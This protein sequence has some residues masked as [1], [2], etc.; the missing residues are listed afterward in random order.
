MNVEDVISEEYGLDLWIKDDLLEKESWEKYR[1]KAPGLI[2]ELE[3][4]E[5][6]ADEMNQKYGTN[7]KLWARQ[8]PFFETRFSVKGM[9]EDEK[10]REIEKHAKAM[11]ETWQLFREWTRNVGREIYTKTTNMRLGWNE[12]ISKVL[13]LLRDF[14]GAKFV[15]KKKAGVVLSAELDS[16]DV[17]NISANRGVGFFKETRDGIV[18]ISDNL[19]TNDARSI[20]EYRLLKSRSGKNK[21]RIAAQKVEDVKPFRGTI[22]TPELVEQVVRQVEVKFAIKITIRKDRP[23]LVTSFNTGDLRPYGKLYEIERHAKALAETWNGIK[24]IMRNQ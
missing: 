7:I 11:Y 24:D 2:A 1:K 9:S 21:N 5:K 3:A 22:I 18:M 17:K 23:V 16:R 19:D 8:K 12:Y 10:L 6:V 15:V 4:A 13:S 20:E 14:T